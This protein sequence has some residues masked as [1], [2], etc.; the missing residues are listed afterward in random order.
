MLDPT[1]GEAAQP[2]RVFVVEDDPE[3]LKV[4]ALYL[5]ALGHTVASSFTV[6]YALERL[7][8]VPYDVL[9]SDISLPDGDA[10]DMMRDVKFFQP[11]YA[12]A[13][14]ARS[15]DEDRAKSKA[16]GFRH[17]LLKPCRFSELDAALRE[18][19]REIRAKG[20]V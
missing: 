3:T 10:W 14:T 6:A 7:A 13:I 17:H 20:V 19:A 15:T 18:A 5:E 9:L 1:P 11:L 8:A 16:A 4:L 2:L 12:I